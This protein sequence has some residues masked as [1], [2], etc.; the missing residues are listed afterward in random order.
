MSDVIDFDDLIKDATQQKTAVKYIDFDMEIAR[1]TAYKN[2][3]AFELGGLP[4]RWL[5]PILMPPPWF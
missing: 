4:K 2:R 3:L 5:H 1:A